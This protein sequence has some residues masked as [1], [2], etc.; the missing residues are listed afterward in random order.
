MLIAVS[1]AMVSFVDSDLATCSGPADAGNGAVSNVCRPSQD[2]VEYLCY[3]MHRL[4]DFRHPEIKSL[5]SFLDRRD[6][7]TPNFV[8]FEPPRG[9]SYL[10]PFW[11]VRLPSKTVARSVAQRSLLVK[12]V[13]TTALVRLACMS[14]LTHVC[15]TSRDFSSCG[16]KV[17]HGMNLLH[18]SKAFQRPAGNAGMIPTSPLSLWSMAG[19]R[20]S[21]RKTKLRSCTSS[22]F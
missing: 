15:P 17:K 2:E 9:G 14:F 8:A 5:V 4:L 7:S 1:A 10:S 16:A 12:V 18:L 11:Y 22:S 20:L 6:D 21:N 19:A 13:L 3:F